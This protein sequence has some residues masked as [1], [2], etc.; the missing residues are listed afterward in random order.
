MKKICCIF[1]CFMLAGCATEKPKEAP[2]DPVQEV[3]E[4]IRVSFLA[5]GDNLIHGAVFSDPYQ[6]MNDGTWNYD[7]F[8]EHVKPY[9]EGVDVKNINQETPLG[10]R[11]LGLK[12]YPMFNGPQEIGTAVVNA[13]FNWISQASNHSMDAGETG[14]LRQMNFWDQYNDS[15]ITTGMNRTQEEADTPRILKV[16]G[17]NIGLLNYTYG[18]NGLETP[19]GKEYLVNVI[20]EAKIK[21]DI[22]SLKKECD[23]MVASMHWGTE[24]QFVENAEQEALAQLLSD[25]GV[26]VIIGAHPHVIQ[27][28]KYITGKDGN[29][30]L[31]MYSLGNFLSAQDQNYRMLGGMGTWDLVKD[32][33]TGKIRIEAVKFYPTVTHFNRI[34][35]NFKVYLL[36]DYTDALASEHYLSTSISR[37]YFID[38]TKEVIGTPEHIEVVY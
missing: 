31:V 17:I 28:M 19:K 5:V 20:D 6:K 11:E 18:L 10:G 37:Q 34:F 33:A 9:L 2:V 12:H 16:K 26:S 25:E 8:Y 21:A 32:G 4:D 7:A 22:A 14:I 35:Q 29:Q 3:K 30:T 1:A 13:G 15:I 36:K 23:V 24:Y 27:P 38:L